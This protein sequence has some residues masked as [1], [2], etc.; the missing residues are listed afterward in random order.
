M[1][2]VLCCVDEGVILTNVKFVVSSGGTH[3]RKKGGLKCLDVSARVGLWVLFGGCRTAASFKPV[4]KSTKKSQ[5]LCCKAVVQKREFGD[6]PCACG[7][8]IFYTTFILQTN[9]LLY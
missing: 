1:A 9:I 4:Y 7:A 8:Q 2:N 5:N 6:V 3:K